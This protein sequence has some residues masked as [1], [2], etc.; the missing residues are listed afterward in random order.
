ML[1]L[2]LWRSRLAPR[3]MALALIVGTFTHPFMPNQVAAGAGLIVAAIGFAGASLALLR[4]SDDEFD[5][6]PRR[7]AR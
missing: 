5:L 6:P 1:G 2:A 7:A 3:W 4:M